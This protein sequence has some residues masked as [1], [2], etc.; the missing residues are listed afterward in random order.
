[1]APD[2]QPVIEPATREDVET[3]TDYWV[4]LAREQRQ[5]DSHVLPDA[6]RETIGETLAAHQVGGGLLVARVDG[7]VVGFASFSLERGTF[8]LDAT[9]GLLS[10]LYVRPA[11]RGRG[12]GTALLEATEEELAQRGA[13]V[14]TLEAMAKNDAARRFY[15]RN[16]YDTH[17]VAMERS[18]D[19]RSENDT[20]SKEEQ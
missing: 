9:R 3:L 18:L 12:I 11:Y 6:N 5:H 8:A 15:R 7:D 19:D 4:D 16:G 10:N 1:M 20:H 17:R 13:D 2:E 14:V